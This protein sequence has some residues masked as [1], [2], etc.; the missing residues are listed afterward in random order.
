MIGEKIGQDDGYPIKV[1]VKKNTAHLDSL[2]NCL[3]KGCSGLGRNEVDA[4]MNAMTDECVFEGT[5][6]VPDGARFQG[7]VAVRAV[8]ERL[9]SSSPQAYFE[10]EDIFAHGDRCVG[11]WIYTLVDGDGNPGRLRGVDVFRV[12]DGKIA[13]KCS[14]VKG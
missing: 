7:Q 1:D 5:G 14:Y 8:W 2:C 3:H 4:I 11:R 6:P 13:E 10:T 12:R 9:F